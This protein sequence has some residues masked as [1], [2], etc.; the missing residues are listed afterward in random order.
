MNA[1]EPGKLIT[2]HKHRQ[3]I[4]ISDTGPFETHFQPQQ[5]GTAILTLHYWVVI[6]K[7][8]FP[9]PASIFSLQKE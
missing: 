9:S 4:L 7:H 1:G 5:T 2:T 3:K 6:S 8:D